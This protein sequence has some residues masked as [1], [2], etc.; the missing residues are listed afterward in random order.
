M[1]RVCILGG[2]GA[3]GSA[4]SKFF[5]PDSDV[6]ILNTLNYDLNRDIQNNSNITECEIFINASGT[7]GGLKSYESNSNCNHS[8]NYLKNISNLIDITKAKVV[9]NISSAAVAFRDNFRKVSPY[10]S[11]VSAKAKLENIFLNKDSHLILNLRCSNIISQYENYQR[12]RHSIASI[13]KA[14]LTS[15]KKVEI[16]SHPD[17]WREYIDADDLAYVAS[18]L[19]DLKGKHTITI[20]SGRRTYI[21]E[22]VETFAE[23]LNFNNGFIFSQPHKK[24]PSIK[25]YGLPKEIKLL[26]GA[27]IT[28]IRQSL[29]KCIEA[30]I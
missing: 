5:S 13:Y 18:L 30:W 27:R 1:K 7:Y 12:S 22:V 15:K 9:V 29:A 8:L 25:P 24:G 10:Y 16:W 2:T 3:I 20:G 11:Y 14:I 4:F 17:D 19:F 6:Q 23:L 28:P 26:G 21:K